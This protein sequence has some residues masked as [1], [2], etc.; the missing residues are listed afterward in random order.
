MEEQAVTIG[1]SLALRSRSRILCTHSVHYLYM[2]E[3]Q[4]LGKLEAIGRLGF[5]NPFGDERRTLE[6][7]ILGSRAESSRTWSRTLDWSPQNPTLLA[8]QREAEAHMKEAQTRLARG[9]AHVSDEERRLIRAV[10]LYVLYYRYEHSFYL[11]ITAAKASPKIEFYDAFRE[12]FRALFERL[13]PPRWASDPARLFA[14]FFQSRRAFH[15]VYHRILGTSRAAAALRSSVWESVFTHDPRRYLEHLQ[16]RMHELSTLVLGPSGTGKELVAS[17][18]GFSSFIEF[19]AEHRRFT[20]DF[21]ERFHPLHLAAMSKTL[22]ESDLF[23]HK[24][25]AFTGAGEDRVGHLERKWPFDTV[26]LDEIGELDGEVQVKLLRVLQSRSFHRLGDTQ[27][28][29]FGG[30]VVAATNRDLSEEMAVGRFREDLYYRL[31]ADIIR[32]PSLYEQ[33]G[34]SLDELRHLVTFIL[35]RT[36]GAANA[37]LVEGIIGRIEASVGARYAWPGNMRELEQ[38]VRNL[39]VHDR[40]TPFE[41]KSPKRGLQPLFSDMERG[42][43]EIDRVMS[44]YSTW[45]Y[46]QKGSFEKAA[47]ALGVDRRTVSKHVDRQLLSQFAADHGLVLEAKSL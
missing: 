4:T 19:D 44:A 33:L 31:C 22:I 34:G 30:K 5:I 11:E 40:Y 9:G 47:E 27:P 1:N 2:L 7:R 37:D 41:A 43:A 45:V 21:R 32:T 39:L 25:G 12:D 35:E 24:K 46:A 36:L 6:A 15:F 13:D 16:G 10:A 17:A 23:G 38:C 8:I 18:I 26:F 28:R 3:P 20:A 42:R 14:I 29:Q